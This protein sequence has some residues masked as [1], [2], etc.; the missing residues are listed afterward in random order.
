MANYENII[1]SCVR[2]MQAMSFI[3]SSISILLALLIYYF[4]QNGYI[5]LMLPITVNGIFLMILTNQ[6]QKNMRKKFHVS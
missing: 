1:N 5:S 4:T 2:E 6:V 3:V